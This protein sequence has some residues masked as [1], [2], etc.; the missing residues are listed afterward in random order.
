MDRL[1]EIETRKA[2]IRSELETIDEVEKVEELNQEVDALN[3]EETEIKESQDRE[4]TAKELEKDSSEA[5][6]VSIEREE[7]KM[8]TKEIRNSAKYVNAYAEY[9]KTGKDEE[10]RTLLTENVNNGTIA[11][12]DFVYDTVK[13]AWDK[14]D[15]MSL[16][17]KSELKGN[18]KIQFEISGTDAVIHTEGSGAVTEEV[19]TE[20]IV[21]IVPANIKKWISI[22]D[23][24]M[25]LRGEAF[26]NYIYSELTYRITKKAADQLVSLIAALPATAT[27]TS[28][29]ANKVNKAPEAVT[30]ATA[31]ANLSDEA[32]N[33][34]I[35]M[36]KLTY[37]NFKAVQYANNY[38]VDVFEGIDVKFNNSLPAYDTASANDVY[39]IVG[40]LGHGALANFP[41]GIETVDFKF[42][43][44]SRKKEDLVEILGK[45]YVGLGLVADK[46][47]A[48][49]TKPTTSSK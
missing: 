19:L 35:I 10:L 42:D 2:E 26:L 45:E 25:E 28:V 36:N 41:N 4:E 16:V 38:G 27:A 47:F 12:P 9:I 30:I 7:R 11:V 37:A 43:E 34:V 29:S 32:A 13:T 46:A 21:T 8:D 3:E 14:N 33:P 39:A 44:L 31:I 24:V 20:G 48:L 17:S 18:L 22:S 49:L 23:E 15:I 1:K 40:D 6:E 5:R